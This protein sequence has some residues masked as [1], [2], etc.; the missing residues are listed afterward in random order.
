MTAVPA[1]EAFRKYLEENPHLYNVFRNQ[2]SMALLV[3]LSG[4]GRFASE[5]TANFP[6]TDALALQESLKALAEGALVE[7]L[8][9]HSEPFY[10][11]TSKGSELVKYYL[12]AR[13]GFQL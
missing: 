1:Q 3:F 6:S 11:L 2:A 13:Q 7:S 10:Y 12:E 9:I 5:V 8:S 4:R